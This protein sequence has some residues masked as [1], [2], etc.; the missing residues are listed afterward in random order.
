MKKSELREMIQE[1]VREEFR[2]TAKKYINAYVPAVIGETIGDLVEKKIVE[3]IGKK[4]NGMSLLEQIEDDEPWPL[5]GGEVQTSTK[6]RTLDRKRITEL[7][8]Y[9]TSAERGNI[10]N[11]VVTD[12]GVEVEVAPDSVPDYLQNALNKDYRPFLRALDDGTR[13]TRG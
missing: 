8:G 13:K 11:K 6:A 12:A 10:V 3:V 5:L 7:L 9:G 2:K 1:I 4:P